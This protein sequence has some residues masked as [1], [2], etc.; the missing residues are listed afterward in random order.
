MQQWQQRLHSMP[1]TREHRGGRAGPVSWPLPVTCGTINLINDHAVGPPLPH[2]A[3]QEA[4][5]Q[6]TKPGGMPPQNEDRRQ[7][8]P[9]EGCLPA[10]LRCR[11]GQSPLLFCWENVAAVGAEH[12][13]LACISTASRTRDCSAPAERSSEA[14][15]STGR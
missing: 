3:L 4:Q 12:M 13:A 11:A 8:P 1:D 6:S 5:A 14:L 9:Q 10:P 7:R 2:H 15:T